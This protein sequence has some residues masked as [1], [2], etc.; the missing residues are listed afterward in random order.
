MEH[1]EHSSAVRIP[2][3]AYNFDEATEASGLS[4]STLRRLIQQ[5]KLL[6]VEVGRRRLIP[7]AALERLVT[8]GAA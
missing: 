1:L 8:E 6:S 5:G 2:K 4:R 3:I 7:R